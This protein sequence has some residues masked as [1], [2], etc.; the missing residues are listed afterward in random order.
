MQESSNENLMIRDGKHAIWRLLSLESWDFGYVL[1]ECK[2]LMGRR[3]ESRPLYL[4]A[5]S[6]DGRLNGAGVYT[7]PVDARSTHRSRMRPNLSC[8]CTIALYA[9]NSLLNDKDH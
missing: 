4:S 1:E 5:S 3:L 7:L 2:M 8:I 6:C 9:P